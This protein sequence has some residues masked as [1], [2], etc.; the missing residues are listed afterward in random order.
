MRLER[1]CSR[2]SGSNVDA[3]SYVRAVF[4]AVGD[5]SVGPDFHFAFDGCVLINREGHGLGRAWILIRHLRHRGRRRGSKGDR[6]R[7][8]LN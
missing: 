5:I 2:R 3:D 8:L 6:E 1:S 4:L 7:V